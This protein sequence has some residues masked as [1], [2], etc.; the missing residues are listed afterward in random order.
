MR[1]GRYAVR[2]TTTHQMSL[3]Y[4]IMGGPQKAGAE[5][6]FAISRPTLAQKDPR[7][8]HIARAVGN[9]RSFGHSRF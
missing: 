2:M 3:N 6:S 8:R 5:C 1:K 7:S 4:N 9:A